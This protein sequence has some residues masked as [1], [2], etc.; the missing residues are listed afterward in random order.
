MNGEAL[1]LMIL[2]EGR[3]SA[4]GQRTKD[5]KREGKVISDQ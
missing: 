1:L 3:K 2:I 5:R 4:M